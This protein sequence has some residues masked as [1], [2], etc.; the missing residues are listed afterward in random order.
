VLLHTQLQLVAVAPQVLWVLMVALAPQHHL[1][2]HLP[3]VAVMVVKVGVLLALA[4]TAVLEEAVVEVMMQH[5]IQVVQQH[6]VKVTLVVLVVT[7]L[8]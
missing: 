7:M 6:Q 1:A 2:A 3:M 5:S 4:V 8:L